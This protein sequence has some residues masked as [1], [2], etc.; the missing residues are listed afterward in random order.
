MW[1]REDFN[2][3][4]RFLLRRQ[5]EDDDKYQSRMDSCSDDA[6]ADALGRLQAAGFEVA[7]N[8][9][10]DYVL[11]NGP[12]VTPSYEGGSADSAT[13][14]NTILPP[15]L[16]VA[17]NESIATEDLCLLDEGEI[18]SLHSLN[19]KKQQYPPGAVRIVLDKYIDLRS[20]VVDIADQMLLFEEMKFPVSKEDK[21]RFFHA[22][23]Q[24]ET[25]MT[26][27]G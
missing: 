22:L 25:M 16:N 6:G 12:I 15:I 20:C 14:S 26:V 11:T 5:G 4:S 19:A 1:S 2:L 7:L 13:A 21:T 9:H 3:A 17:D 8:R 10:G 23:F 24:A 18:A 27:A